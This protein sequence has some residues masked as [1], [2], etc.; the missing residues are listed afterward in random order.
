[1][2]IGMV[3]LGKLGFPI[4]HA[5]A[6][7]GHDVIG[8]DIKEDREGP[9]IGTLEELV[10]HS[11]IVFVAVQTPHEHK[12]GGTCLLDGHRRDFDYS[13]LKQAVTDIMEVET[14]KQKT[15]AIIST[16]T[17][18]TIRQCIFSL[19]KDNWTVCYNPFFIAMGT[20]VEDFYNPEFVLIGSDDATPDLV[21]FYARTVDAPIYKTT[22]ENAEMT[23]MA[24]NTFITMKIVFANTIMEMC[25]QLDH[26]DVDVVTGIL[27]KAH[28]RLISPAYLFGGMGDGGACH[29]RD[30]I[31]LSSMARK[32]DIGYDLF[33]DLIEAREAQADALANKVFWGRTESHQQVLILGYSFKALSSITEGSCALLVKE[34]LEKRY[35]IEPMLYDPYV[36]EGTLKRPTEPCVI[37]IGTKHP[38]FAEMK[39]MEG[40][41]IIDPWRYIPEQEGVEIVSIGRNV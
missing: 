22:I 23:K 3:G 36:D 33:G 21:D 41:V 29:P 17:P 34:I 19:V 8:Y 39:F 7:K 25:D 13:Y 5:M 40:D 20:E 4:A 35:N 2:K 31:A 14:E 32:L 11:K 6:E 12:F 10:H 18:R 9:I 26:A 30:N 38:C 24:Y 1:M 37:L 15:L 27:S 16:V 28:K